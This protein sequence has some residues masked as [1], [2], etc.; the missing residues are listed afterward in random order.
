M[1]DGELCFDEELFSRILRNETKIALQGGTSIFSLNL[2]ISEK[3]FLSVSFLKQIKQSVNYIYN[4]AEQGLTPRHVGIKS[5]NYKGFPVPETIA[6]HTSVMLAIYDC[7]KDSLSRHNFRCPR[8]VFDMAIRHHDMAENRFVD[9]ANNHYHDYDKI[10]RDLNE[11]EFFYKFDQ[12]IPRSLS[13]TYEKARRLID[14]AYSQSTPD[15]RA[16]YLCDKLAAIIMPLTSYLN[17]RREITANGRDNPPVIP[18]IFFTFSENCKAT[19]HEKEILKIIRDNCIPTQSI[20]AYEIYTGDYFGVTKMYRYDDYGFFT[21]LLIA[22]TLATTG[23][24]YP[25]RE[26]K[27]EPTES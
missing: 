24:W 10:D 4:H 21:D 19:P 27:Y 23:T 22:Y 2:T 6:A 8:D 14:E 16:F 12:Y 5:A 18:P 7:F 3:S 17:Y 1:Y 25:W 26:A 11:A 20:P 15:G 9:Y 13:D